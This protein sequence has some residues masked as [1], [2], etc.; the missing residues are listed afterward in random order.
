[1]ITFILLTL[2]HEG[3]RGIV[4]ETVKNRFDAVVKQQNHKSLC[5]TH[6]ESQ[7]GL[8]AQVMDYY[9]MT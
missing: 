7:A 9:K 3:P 6:K 2:T 1:M 5:L 4:L 8:S